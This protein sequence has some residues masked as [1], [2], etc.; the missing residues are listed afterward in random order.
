MCLPSS[1]G[2]GPKIFKQKMDVIDKKGYIADPERFQ[3]KSLELGCGDRKRHADALGVDIRDFAGVDLVGDAESVLEAIPT[4]AISSVYT[5]HFLEHLTDLETIITL[6]ARVLSTG[7]RF[8]AVAPHFSNPYFYSDPTHRTPFGLY[9]FSYFSNDRL[10]RRKVPHYQK[11]VFF[12][13]NHVRLTFKSPPPFYGR[14]IFKKMAGFFFN[15][16]PYL[17]EWY[18]ENACHLIPCYEIAYDLTRNDIPVIAK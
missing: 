16:R 18:E 2:T 10:F 6:V 14:Y 3:G 8:I 12:N 11:D 9:T 1:N 5:Y 15:F 7:G 13:L 17:K 4:G